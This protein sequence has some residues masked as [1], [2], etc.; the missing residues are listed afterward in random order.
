MKPGFYDG[1][2]NAEYHGGP[3]ISKSGLD[4][5]ARSPLHYRAVVEAANENERQPT[6]AQALGT[7]FHA[8]LLEPAEFTK[9]YCLA[10]RQADVPDAIADRDTLLAMVAELNA[11]RLPKLS[12]SGAKDELVARIMDAPEFHDSND[13]VTVDALKGETAA[14]LKQRI[15]RINEHRP[16]LLSDKGTMAEL[17]AILRAN[18]RE[19]TLWSE[20]KQS[21]LENNGHRTVLDADAWDQLHRM[22]DAVMAH[23]AASALLTAVPG[24][25]ERSVYWIDE[26]TGQLCRCRPDF[27]RQ[28]G[29]VVDVKTTLDASPTGFAKSIANWRYHVQHPYYLDGINTM[30]KQLQAASADAEFPPSV[31]AEARAFVFLAVEKDACVVDGQAKGVAVYMLDSESVAL[32]RAEYRR[33]LDQYAQCCATG[34]WPGYGDTIQSLTV[35]RW[36]FNNNPELLTAA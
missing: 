26:T 23:P 15:E 17:A 27:W 19:I 12:T 7:A 3:G 14:L 34:V 32:G 6:P 20:V 24:V 31:P 5:I 8:L 22:R 18:G 28:D 25:A 13:G 21:W 4:L 2:A 1:I 35:P 33:D 10:L 11:G 9:D 36:A 29:I 16:G 30:R